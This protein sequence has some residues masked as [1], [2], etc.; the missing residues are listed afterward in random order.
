M[1]SSKRSFFTTV[2]MTCLSL[3][4][5]GCGQ[6]EQQYS[7]QEVQTITPAD[8]V[9]SWLTGLTSTGEL[10]S[11]AD[12][13]REVVATLDLPEQAKLSQ[14]FDSLLKLRNPG[15]IKAKANEML[16]LLPSDK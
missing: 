6:V 16:K 15:Q 1:R 5:A 7:Q 14:E 13:I 2:A 11:G 12:S 8:N 4:S 3:V 10:D 9:R